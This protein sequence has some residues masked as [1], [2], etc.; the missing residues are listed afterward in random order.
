MRRAAEIS[1]DGLYRYTLTRTWDDA[2]PGVVWCM[3]NPSIADAADEDPTV[4]KCIGFAKRW[5]FGQISIVNLFALISTDAKRLGFALDVWGPENA[6]AL[7]RLLTAGT[8]KIA[9][10]GGSMPSKPWAGDT[11]R[12][13]RNRARR[14]PG[15]WS[16]LG[17]TKAGE[18]RHPLMLAYATPREPWPEVSE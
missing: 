6:D 12:R 16:C 11:V 17:K 1:G 10:W 4:R 13:M 18:P 15:E 3:L 2:L 5:G 8:Q 14:Q 9:A 7:E